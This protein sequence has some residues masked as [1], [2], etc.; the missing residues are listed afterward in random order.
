MGKFSKKKIS[1]AG[2]MIGK[3]EEEYVLDALRNGWYATFE[4]HTKMLEA[5]VCEYLGRKYALGTHCCTLALHLACASAGL[6]KGDEVICTDFSWVATAYSIVYTGATPVF[7]DID[8]DTWCISPQAIEAAITEKTKAIMLVHSFGHPAQMDKIMEIAKKHNLKVIEDAAP[9]LGSKFDGKKTGTFGDSACF[10]FQGAKIAVSGE[11]GIFVTD[12]KEMYERAVL[13]A[14]MGR[15][16]SKKNFWSDFVGYQY[17]IG[18]LPASLA[19]A[20]VERIDELVANKRKIFGW[21]YERLKNVEGIKLIKEK[22]KCFSNYTYP[23]ALLEEVDEKKRNFIVGEFAKRNIHSRAAFP[24][25]STF[26]ALEARYENPECKK[27]EEQGISL[28]AAHNL[29]EEDVEFV[30]DSLLELLGKKK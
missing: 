2:P 25:M 12:D 23:S 10:S 21:Y 3:K 4:K 28:P 1:F 5:K 20:Q 16:N 29:V 26:P 30:C 17:T 9:S 6:K 22:E 18:N 8:P 19:L 11:G 27:V 24:R 7:V 15:T 14:N 13:L